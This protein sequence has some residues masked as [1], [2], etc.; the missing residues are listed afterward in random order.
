M[1]KIEYKWVQPKICRG[2]ILPPS[3][4]VE[5][6]MTHEKPQQ[7]SAGLDFADGKCTFCEPNSYNDGSMDSCQ[8][9]P[10]STTPAYALTIDTWKTELNE[11]S[12]VG[13]LL[14]M[15]CILSGEVA[16]EVDAID[17][18]EKWQVTP[19]MPRSYLRTSPFAQLEAYM[20]LALHI[21]G[22]RHSSG[23]I[24]TFE[25]DLHGGDS[26]LLFIETRDGVGSNSKTDLIEQWRGDTG[27]AKVFRYEVHENF[28]ATYS[29]MY[30]RSQHIQVRYDFQLSFPNSHFFLFSRTLGSTQSL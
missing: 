21:N 29:W 14:A 11:V 16:A 17:C 26:S 4:K 5:C 10:P 6:N 8:R 1:Q 9:C 24:I 30:R 15:Q 3:R 18:D 19:A 27:G 7:C 12:S 13:S 2:D 23:G 20:I 28:S 25:F 22:Y